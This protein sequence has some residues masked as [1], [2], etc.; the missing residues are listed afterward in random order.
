MGNKLRD[1]LAGSIAIGSATPDDDADHAVCGRLYLPFKVAADEDR[2]LLVAECQTAIEV[3]AAKIVPAVTS[4]ANAT[5]FVSVGFGKGDQAA[6]AL[7]AVGTTLTTATVALTAQMARSF[8]IVTASDAN[9]VAKDTSLYL[10]FA[11][12]AAGVA[13]EGVLEVTYKLQG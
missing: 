9:K 6:G 11:Q 10:T 1:A 4:S 2:T 12:D 5:N 13:S 8:V 7:T 3:L